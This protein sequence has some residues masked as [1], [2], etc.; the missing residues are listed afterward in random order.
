MHNDAIY[1]RSES[2][3][4][5]LMDEAIDALR[6][7]SADQRDEIARK[8]LQVAGVPADAVHVPDAEEAAELDESEAAAD[9]GEFATEDE[10]RAIWAK[11]GL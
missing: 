7:V 1:D 2:T 8:V 6:L 4:S 11:H 3:M 9:R 5:D 10:V